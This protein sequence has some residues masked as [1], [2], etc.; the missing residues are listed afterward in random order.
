VASAACLTRAGFDEWDSVRIA[1][2]GMPELT[3]I[4]I[5]AIGHKVLLL[6]GEING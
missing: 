4:G 5:A 1:Q 6:K 3:C 2:N